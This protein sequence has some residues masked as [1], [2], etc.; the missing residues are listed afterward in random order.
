M[1]EEKPG[2]HY[3]ATPGLSRPAE[4]PNRSEFE[5]LLRRTTEI[6]RARASIE[7]GRLGTENSKVQG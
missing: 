7:Q 2:P 3:Q 1:F 6:L 5:D 4:G